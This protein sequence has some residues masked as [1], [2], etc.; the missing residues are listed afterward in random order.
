MT[1]H[2]GYD[3]YEAWKGWDAYFTVP[4]RDAEYF[5]RE[6]KGFEPRDQK[7]LEIGFGTGS[8]LAWCQ[9]RGCAVWGSEISDRSCAEAQAAG[10]PL[11]PV[12]FAKAAQEH[13]ESFDLIAAF[14][15]LEHLP[16]A[17]LADDLMAL[18]A[19]LKPGGH[20][21]A[22]FPNGQSP[23]G[24]VP[25]NGDITHLTALSLPKLQQIL[26][27]GAFKVV[28]YAG[29]ESY[30]GPLGPKWAVRWLRRGAQRMVCGAIKSIFATEAPMEPVVTVVL[31]KG[32]S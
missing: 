8:F 14:D 29:A 22:R 24:L 4:A 13:P 31:R 32:E 11:L 27:A 23:F 6:T 28:R 17:G 16:T 21:I 2:S 10:V 3:N 9:S 25:Q 30:Y 12:S 18:H 26:P 5:T 7:V 15:V 1:Q 20:L 19:M